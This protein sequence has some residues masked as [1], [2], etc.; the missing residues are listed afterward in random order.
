M[1]FL[2]FERIVEYFDAAGLPHIH[3]CRMPNERFTAALNFHEFGEFAEGPVCNFAAQILGN[4]SIL[5]S[6][7]A[8]SCLSLFAEFCTQLSKIAAQCEL[9]AM[10]I[11]HFEVEDEMLGQTFGLK[12]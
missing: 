3:Q 9:T 8:E 1:C 11:N 2:C 5:L 10:L 7:V 6:N 12:V 4:G